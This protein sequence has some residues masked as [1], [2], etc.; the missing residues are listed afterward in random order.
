MKK[1][2]ILLISLIAS[3]VGIYITSYL[4]DV[5]FRPR[6]L[7][8]SKTSEYRHEAIPK[9]ISMLTELGLRGGYDV[10]STEESIV[11]TD[12]E[13]KKYAAVIFLNTTGDVLDLEQQDS[14]ERYIQA[15]GGFVGIHAAADTEWRENGWYWYQRLIGAVFSSHPDDSSQMANLIGTNAKLPSTPE[16]QTNWQVSDEWYDYRRVSAGIKVLQTVDESSYNGGKMGA[17]HPITWFRDFDGGRSF[18][19]GLGHAESTYDSPEFQSLILAGIKYAV[20]ENKLDYSKS[21]PESWRFSRV[22][23]ESGLNEPIKITFSPDGHL[24]F[25]ERKGDIKRYDFDA[26][27]AITVAELDVFTEQ[28]YGL[29]GIAF[30]PDFL[31]NHWVYFYRALPNGK[32]A[33][34]VLSR[35]KLI[36]DVLVK[37]SEQELLSIPGDGNADVR[38]NHTGGDMQLDNSG[39]LWLTTGDDTEADDHG[40]IDDRPGLEF[41]DAARSA[42]NTQDLRGKILRIKPRDYADNDGRLYDIPEGNL[43][44][45]PAEGRPEIYIMGLRNPYTIAYDDHTKTLYWGEVGPDGR[46]DD[47]RGPMGYDEINRSRHPGN[48][49]WPYAIANNQPYHYYD[50]SKDK[51]LDVVNIDAPEN[52]SRNNTGSSFLPPAKPAWIYYPY[53]DSDKFFE[54]GNGGRNALVTK[55]FYSSDYKASDIKFPSYYDGKLIIGDFMR[56]WLKVVNTDA[57]GEVESITPLLDEIFSAPLDMAFGPDGALYVLEYGT[58]WF[59]ANPDAYLSRVEYYSG[60]NPPPIAIATASKMAG[61]APL[62]ALLDGSGSYDRGLGSNQLKYRWVRLDNGEIVEEIGNQRQ[63][64][65]TLNAVGEQTIQLTVI[66]SSGSTSTSRL[67]LFVGN[68]RPLVEIELDGNRSFYRES[69]PLKYRVNVTDLEDGSTA[70]NA[71][72]PKAVT[73]RFDYISQKG[74]LAKVLVERQLDPLTVGREILMQGSDCHACHQLEADSIAPSFTAISMRYQ[75]KS[76]AE[77]YLRKVIF[78]GGSGQWQSSHAMP[79]HPG[80]SERELSAASSYILSLASN[81]SDNASLPIIGHINFDLHQK[82]ALQVAGEKYVDIDLKE[83]YQGTYLLQASY[84]DQGSLAPPLRGNANIVLRHPRQTIDLVSGGAGYRNIILSDTLNCLMLLASAQSAPFVHVK[85]DS[86][87]LTGISQIRV[88]AV[89]LQPY[90]SGG[91]MEL[92]LDDPTSGSVAAIDISAELHPDTYSWKTLDVSEINGIHDLYIGSPVTE[93]NTDKGLYIIYGFEFMFKD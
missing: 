21:K 57:E 39:L 59:Q 23:L 53:T 82:D 28:E 65:V 44:S 90:L 88:G 51:V 32:T 40:R 72:D 3:F 27:K 38:T 1:N 2:Y 16:L 74:D 56:R 45:D 26:K 87:D 24:Y 4:V 8:F 17:H 86:I 66:D 76:D 71:I 15:G 68:E 58:S 70:T 55:P 5:D 50:K 29:L 49:G 19:T 60:D 79:S 25:I 83:M 22:T 18:Y 52:R 7:V 48:F 93:K 14:F 35:F 91:T 36:N 13:L 89:G 64:P 81:S 92:R 11:F 9:G 54:L 41:H 33:R 10:T 78:E 47:A 80:L 67:K 34:L 61:A 42:S 30:D 46:K 31:N 62:Q 75:K 77:G 20:G 43:F 63:Q 84:T 6:I 12:D 69:R 73:I 85:L 37:N